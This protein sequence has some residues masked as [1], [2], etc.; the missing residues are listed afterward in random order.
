MSWRRWL[1]LP[2]VLAVVSAL[3]AVFL[4][5]PSETHTGG[6]G[7]DQLHHRH[8]RP[9]Q[10][11]ASSSTPAGDIGP[12]DQVSVRPEINGLVSELPVDIGDTVKKGDLLFA[13]SQTTGT[14]SNQTLLAA[15]RHRWQQTAG[16][17]NPALL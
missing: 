12:A 3:S 11:L 4:D 13:T 14:P 5:K 8:H 10:R 1:F 16:G 9:A 6:A 7:L 17:K 15:D 2:T